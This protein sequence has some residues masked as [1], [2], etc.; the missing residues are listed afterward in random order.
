MAELIPTACTALPKRHDAR[1]APTTYW[2]FDDV[3]RIVAQ[4]ETGGRCEAPGAPIWEWTNGDGQSFPF[5]ADANPYGELWPDL[6]GAL[7]TDGP[8][9]LYATADSTLLHA[10]PRPPASG[11]GPVRIV[12]FDPEAGGAMNPKQPQEPAEL[13]KAG[14]SAAVLT[15]ACEVELSSA[16][17]LFGHD[18]SA[19]VYWRWD[20]RLRTVSKPTALPEGV[21]PVTAAF[22]GYDRTRPGGP[23]EVPRRITRLYSRAREQAFVVTE[24]GGG[25]TFAP[26]EAV[27][28]LKPLDEHVLRDA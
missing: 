26:C 16:V 21:G 8:Q 19:P 12:S 13:T 1:G 2:F 7:G 14:V 6:A 22:L 9:A 28:F 3:V 25:L 27:P 11:D 5:A 23:A 17:V 15:A 18:G 10:I 20:L 4:C 24:S